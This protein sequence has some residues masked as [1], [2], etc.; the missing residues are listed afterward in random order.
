MNARNPVLKIV[1]AYEDLANG[2][3]ATAMLS[4]LAA[5]LETE[6]QIKSDA[7]QIDNSV[8]K[9]ELLRDPELRKQA[10]AEA[11]AADMIILSVCNARLPASV[12]DWIESVLPMKEGRP[13]ALVAL[14]DGENDT[15]GEPPRPEAYLRRL[16]EQN[17]LDFFC[18]TD[19]RFQRVESGI[20]STLSPFRGRFSNLEGLFTRIAPRADGAPMNASCEISNIKTN[21]KTVKTYMTT[22]CFILLL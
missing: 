11:V 7:W 2:I 17:G 14:F 19:G 15:S 6:F 22:L 21:I 3:E 4:R 5:Q 8:W 18:N 9:F 10:A 16:A 1:I 20:E 13:A 12:S